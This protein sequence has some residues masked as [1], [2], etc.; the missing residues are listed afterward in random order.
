MTYEATDINGGFS[1][2]VEIDETEHA[3]KCVKTMVE[4]WSGAE[5]RLDHFDGNYN[6]A[7]IHQLAERIM[8][9]TLRMSWRNALREIGASEGYCTLD[10]AHGI[11][12]LS[13]GEYEL[14]QIEVEEMSL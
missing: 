11:R 6:K 12:V 4:F 10:G 8:P 9:M 14:P 5:E 7:F 13:C 3:D 2:T 1:M